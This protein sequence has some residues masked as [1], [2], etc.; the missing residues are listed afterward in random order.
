MTLQL[1]KKTLN[2]QYSVSLTILQLNK[3]TLNLQYTTYRLILQLNNIVIN[4]SSQSK[5]HIARTL[6]FAILFLRLP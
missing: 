2:L 6:P 3:K 5:Q 4:T 1:N